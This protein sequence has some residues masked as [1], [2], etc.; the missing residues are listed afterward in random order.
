MCSSDLRVYNKR[1]K[2]MVESINV[3]IDD[4]I[5]EKD[6]DEGDGPNLKKNEGDDN[7]SQGEDAEKE[8]PE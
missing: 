5:S 2:T 3:V 8:S 6:I 4:T 7:M 1:T